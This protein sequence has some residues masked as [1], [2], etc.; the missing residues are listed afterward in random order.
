MSEPFTVLQIIILEN[1]QSISN[2]MSK[3][4]NILFFGDFNINILDIASAEVIH[5]KNLVNMD[6]FVILNSNNVEHATRIF[7]PLT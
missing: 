4:K 6:G 7:L 1:L 3:F 5:F 2:H